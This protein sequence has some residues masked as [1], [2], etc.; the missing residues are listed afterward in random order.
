MNQVVTIAIADDHTLMRHGIKSIIESYPGFKVV[1]ESEG[2]DDTIQVVQ[3]TTPDILILDLGLPER[4]G[5]EVIYEI[6]EHNLSTRVAVLTRHDDEMMVLQAFVAGARAY[7]LKDFTPE[8]LVDTLHKVMKGEL[9]LPEHFEYMRPEI[10]KRRKEVEQF[11]SGDSDPLHKLSKREREIFFHLANG[12]PN[13]AIAKRLYISP[14]TV[15][16]HRARVLKKMD[17]K[18]TADLIKY[19]IKTNLLTP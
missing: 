9:C 10:S 1:G 7:I 14:R 6:E 5:I 3:Q 4:S 13:R 15:E 16:T 2:A 19:A 11:G 18:S 8:Q 12:L 17:F